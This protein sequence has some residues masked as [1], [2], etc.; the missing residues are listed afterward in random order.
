[1][2]C[3]TI[4]VSYTVD[5]DWLLAMLPEQMTLKKPI[6]TDLSANTDVN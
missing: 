5:K 6:N 3:K 4:K 2:Y 1:M